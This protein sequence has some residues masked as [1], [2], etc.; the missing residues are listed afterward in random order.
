MAD[1]AVN[2]ALANDLA[3]ARRWS[4]TST[5]GG[6]NACNSRRAF[7]RRFPELKALFARTDAATIRDFLLTYQQQ[8]PGTPLLVALGP[9][10]TVL[11]RTDTTEI[12]TSDADEWLKAVAK[13]RRAHDRVR[14]RPSVSR[15]ERAATPAE[16]CSDTSSPPPRR[17]GVRARDRGSHGRRDDPP[18]EQGG[19][20][21][22]ASGECAVEIT[23]GLAAAGRAYRPGDDRC[24][25]RAAL[26]RT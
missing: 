20:G 23:R 5:P 22:D 26:R 25:R 3:R 13:A 11:G 16:S 14:R 21:V 1:R 9:S 15:R 8:N 10:G 12:M 4:P 18:V 24:D 19:A 7:W 17:F 6:S 2:A